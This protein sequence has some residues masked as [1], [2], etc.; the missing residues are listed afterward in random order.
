M[1]EN[2]CFVW[3][4]RSLFID[5]LIRQMLQQKRTHW[6]GVNGG[7]QKIKSFIRAIM[8]TEKGNLYIVKLNKETD[9]TEVAKYIADQIANFKFD[10]NPVH[11][12]NIMKRL[13]RMVRAICHMSSSNLLF[14]LILTVSFIC[15]CHKGWPRMELPMLCE[16][17]Q[18][19]QW[20]CEYEVYVCL[21][22][23][24]MILPFLLSLILHAKE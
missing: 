9:P 17:I 8:S 23:Y 10:E 7:V 1:C 19:W 11:L 20:I 22:I 18:W 15:T 5:S 4:V 14:P 21:A 16:A 6:L 12:N 2:I 13:E 24:L 3:R